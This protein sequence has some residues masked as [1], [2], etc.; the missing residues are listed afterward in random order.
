MSEQKNKKVTGIGGVFFKSEDP[1]TLKKWYTDQLG[2]DTDAYGATFKFRQFREPE[3]SG[4]LQWS[5]FK[6]DTTYFN[7]S[8]KPFM[9][10][11]RVADIEW[12]VQ[13][14]RQAGVTICDEIETFDYGKFV[15][16]LDPEGNKIELWEPVDATFDKYYEEDG[17]RK[18]N[19]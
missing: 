3:K 15:H 19:Y 18:T 12:L 8:P 16:I 5:P 2:I 9:I 4:Y 1:D 10:N 7:P 11:Y 13:E 17:T 6:E 14:L